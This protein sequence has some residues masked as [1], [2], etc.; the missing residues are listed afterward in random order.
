ML[1][2]YKEK[3]L[4]RLV[5]V[6]ITPDPITGARSTSA[7]T[8]RCTVFGTIAKDTL[9]CA[10]DA[11]AQSSDACA[12]LKSVAGGMMFFATWADVSRLV[13]LQMDEP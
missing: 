10:L 1:D 12:P 3:E 11:L 7:G 2:K 8:N 4:A 13:Y 6:L 5:V 9:I